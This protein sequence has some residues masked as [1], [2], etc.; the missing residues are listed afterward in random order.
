MR[1]KVSLFLLLHVIFFL[2]CSKQPVDF[3][4]LQLNDVDG[5]YYLR[6]NFEEPYTGPV[7]NTDQDGY[8]QGTE[9]EGFLKDGRWDGSFRKYNSNIDLIVTTYKDGNIHG[10]YISYHKDWFEPHIK[11]K[12]FYNNGILDGPFISYYDKQNDKYHIELETTFKNGTPIGPTYNLYYSNGNLKEER[13]YVDGLENGIRKKFTEDNQLISE[14][15]FVNG[16]M[17][18]LSRYFFQLNPKKNSNN[19]YIGKKIRGMLLSKFTYKEGVLNGPF[20]TFQLRRENSNSKSNV[21]RET[22]GTYK[23]NLL[24]GQIYFYSKNNDLEVKNFVRGVIEGPY[25]KY[26]PKSLRNYKD[27]VLVEEGQYLNDYPYGDFKRYDPNT[28]SIIEEFTFTEGGILNGSVKR[29]NVEGDIIYE[30]T[31]LNNNL[32]GLIKTFRNNGLL[33]S[34]YTFDNGKKDGPFS[35]YDHQLII[36]P[37]TEDK[38][39]FFNNNPTIIGSFK[40]DQLDGPYKEYK[41]FN[42][43]KYLYIDSNYKDGNLHG[44]YVKYQVDSYRVRYIE[45]NKVYKWEESNYVDGVLHGSYKEYYDV[46]IRYYDQETLKLERTYN[47]GKIIEETRY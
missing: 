23:N 5:L 22:S 38:L 9:V 41:F 36:F 46:D 27:Y 2:S 26:E 15:S 20:K 32:D 25:K 19:K 10:S 43:V 6:G 12:S 35:I 1:I 11:E 24:D 13:K 44:K 29:Y 14:E 33:Y 39:K 34:K 17:D 40:Y 28:K 37:I 8:I 42:G 3:N 7:S 45:D 21:I 30:G 31:Y 47:N 16:K 4:Q 18:G